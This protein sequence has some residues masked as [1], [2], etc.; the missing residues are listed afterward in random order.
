MTTTG[1]RLIELHDVRK[2]YRVGDE[3][4][5]ALAG[6]DLAIAS[7]EFVAVVGPSGSGKS[8]LMH[9]LGFMDRPTSGRMVFDGQDVSNLSTS[10]QATHRARKLGFVFQAF[11]LLPRLSVL[12]NVL[13]P[14]TYAQGRDG[15]GK[16]RATEV[17]ERVG[18]THRSRHR[19][20]Q[21]SGGERQRVAIAR[22]LVN[23]P[24]LLLADE[25]TGNLDGENVD[26]LLQLFQELHAEGQ[27][28][29]LVTHDTN[30]AAT[31]KRQIRM[32][33]G[34]VIP[35]SPP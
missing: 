12:E 30:V 7:G 23:Q 26:R 8:T 16:R 1:H 10:A 15:A 28:I 27:T 25:P 24:R 29:V 19:P 13:L 34:R 4:V 6:V 35:P 14:L 9:L 17:L 22:A 32:K 5:H 33:N 2:T 18:L 3:D 11:N 31:A 20:N 21:L